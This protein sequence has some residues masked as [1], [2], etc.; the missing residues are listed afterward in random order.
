MKA[1]KSITLH[2]MI[3]I[4]ACGWHNERVLRAKTQFQTPIVI[5]AQ[6]RCP[7]AFQFEG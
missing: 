3:Q 2:F 4:L 1:I 6:I 5:Q 7:Y